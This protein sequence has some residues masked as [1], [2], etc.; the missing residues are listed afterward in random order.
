[1]D[2]TISNDVQLVR[3]I[4][5]D[6]RILDNIVTAVITHLDALKE[7]NESYDF[8]ADIN[9]LYDAEIGDDR[10]VYLSMTRSERIIP[11]KITLNIKKS[12][13]KPYTM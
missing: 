3:K 4:N 13:Y 6:N 2:E 5:K 10:E 8:V 1:M 12:K 11:I 7:K 9:L